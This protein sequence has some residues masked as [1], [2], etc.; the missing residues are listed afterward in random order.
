MTEAELW[1][2]HLVAVANTAEAFQG[3]LTIVFA[4]LVTAYFVGR[5]LTR[6][7][8]ALVSLLFLL[9]AVG[10]SFMSIVEFRRAVLFMGQLTSRF[11]VE[12]ISPNAVIIPLYAVLMGLLISAAVY[13]MYQIRR[14]PDLGGAA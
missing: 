1:Q 8:S 12:S 2:L 11:G 10:A 13:F 5:R 6:F 7:Q 3:V 4:Y 14:N 9:G